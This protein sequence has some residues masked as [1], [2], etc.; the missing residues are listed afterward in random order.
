M[1]EQHINGMTGI[2]MTYNGK[3]YLVYR[4]IGLNG[5]WQTIVYCKGGPKYRWYW[6]PVPVGKV[7][8]AV[9]QQLAE[10]KEMA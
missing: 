8:A 9:L 4:R 6:R 1:V 5:R 7:Y 10:M 2:P 3:D